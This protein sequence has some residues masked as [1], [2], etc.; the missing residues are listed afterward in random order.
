MPVLDLAQRQ[1][2]GWLPLS[3]M[4]HVAETLQVPAIRVYEVATFYTMYKRVP[5][6][7]FHIQVNQSQ[8]ILGTFLLKNQ[9]FFSNFA[10][11]CSEFFLRTQIKSTLFTTILKKKHVEE[12]SSFTKLEKIIKKL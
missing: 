12:L 5:V 10:V 2:G 9:F 4:N 11:F 8:K 1:Y 3:V 6:G 7:K